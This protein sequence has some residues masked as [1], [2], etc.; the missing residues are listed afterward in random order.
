MSDDGPS[1]AR[2][3]PSRKFARI[4][5]LVSAV[6]D[7]LIHTVGRCTIAVGYSDITTLSVDA[8]VSSDDPALSMGGGVSEAIRLA[9][10]P[11]VFA[12]AQR[13]RPAQLG[14]VVVTGGGRLPATRVF[15]GIVMD[16]DEEGHPHTTP[17]VITAVVRRCLD[18]C[19]EYGVRSIA[20]P[21][22]A[23]G[24]AGLE[25]ERSAAAMLVEILTHLDAWPILERIQI[26]LD[27][28]RRP[29]VAAR[30]YEQVEAYFR[31]TGVARSMERE[32]AQLEQFQPRS[33]PA[34]MGPDRERL[35]S[36]RT[37][38]DAAMLAQDAS[39]FSATLA[40]QASRALG[41]TLGTIGSKLER[42]IAEAPDAA[43]T[44]RAQA[45]RLWAL[46]EEARRRRDDIERQ[47][48]RDGATTA[49]HQQ[50]IAFLL[51]REARFQQE[52]AALQATSRPLVISVHGIRTRGRWQK[53][54]TLPLSEA[55]FDHK[56]V[57]YGYFGL[58]QFL[59]PFAR[60]SRVDAFRDEYQRLGSRTASGTPSLIAHSL[61]TYIVTRAMTKYDL[62][63]DR[64]ILCGAIVP[65]NYD[66]DAV[67]R[68]GSVS[69]VLNDCG[70]QD[71]WA[72]LARRA[73][74]DAGQSG[75]TG[76]ERTAGG[77]VVN[78]NHA[79]FGH[80]DYF[81]ERNYLDAWIPFLKGEDLAEPIRL[82]P[83][84]TNRRVALTVAL[85]LAAAAL[86]YVLR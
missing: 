30:F 31:L 74:S 63:F 81:Y 46:I 2:S 27:P 20:L 58:L 15:H 37:E 33:S 60:R 56:P 43:S 19:A 45:V 6:R 65:E 57:D 52:L 28:T 50:Q 86:F 54:I 62:K 83:T 1:S 23:T 10:G 11:E 70:Q 67:V 71:I 68:R 17:E 41:D 80:S 13:Q 84:R 5:A 34:G 49:A 22:L 75:L 55:G 21:A 29:D 35:A 76:F 85:L 82:Q 12:A 9:A 61:G 64:M 4:L 3:D 40:P 7:S 18:L 51:E 48:L 39:A 26:A 66:W 24:A 16:Y 78:R 25:P 8:I 69:R 73:V 47:D 72:Q 77:K 32:V 38:L 42:V 59:L 53:D 79:E 14:D 36:V 44:T